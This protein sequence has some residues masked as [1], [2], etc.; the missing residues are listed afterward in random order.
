MN[1]VQISK[2]IEIDDEKAKNNNVDIQFEDLSRTNL[3]KNVD[4]IILDGFIFIYFP[5]KIIHFI[6][7]KCL[8]LVIMKKK[9]LV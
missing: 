3:K 7:K 5:M 9:H 1:Y 6:L 4:D 8:N 2:L